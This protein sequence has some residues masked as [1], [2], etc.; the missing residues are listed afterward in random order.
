MLRGS[1]VG[2]RV[3]L[4]GLDVRPCVLGAAVTLDV[5]DLPPGDPGLIE[6]ELQRGDGPCRLP[7]TR[8]WAGQIALDPAAS[9]PAWVPPLP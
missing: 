7:L 2:A 3:V 4:D 1:V 6:L 8:R 9:C 5:A